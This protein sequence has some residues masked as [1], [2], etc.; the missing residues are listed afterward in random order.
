MRT[1]GGTLGHPGQPRGGGALGVQHW[2]SFLEVAA[3]KV[4]SLGQTTAVLQ[5]FGPLRKQPP[6]PRVWE[7][8]SPTRQA[9]LGPKKGSNEE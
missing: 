4:G 5:T 2:P 9:S 6:D 8:R 3:G 1:K 7:N